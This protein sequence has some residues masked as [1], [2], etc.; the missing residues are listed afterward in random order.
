[1]PKLI[2]IQISVFNIQVIIT[3]MKSLNVDNMNLIFSTLVFNTKFSFSVG[4][5][6]FK[7][8]SEGI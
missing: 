1:M 4:F 7:S 3:K 6:H 5:G 8:D 2:K